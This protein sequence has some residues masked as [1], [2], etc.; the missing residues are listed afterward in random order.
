MGKF[1]KIQGEKKRQYGKSLYIKGFDLPT[2]SDITEVA[3]STLKKWRD[4]DRWE[5][6]RNSSF[7]ALS[8]LRNTILQSFIELKDGK[9]PKIK[10]DEAAKYAAAFE[11]LSDKK[12]VLCYMYEA[13]EMLT[14]ELT[15]DI[16]DTKGK[17]EK[18][19]ALEIL[20]RVRTHTD[21][22]ITKLTNET[23]ND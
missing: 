15:K 7:I 13:F 23:L 4:A 3:L 16:Q 14:C 17:K 5:T 19:L 6:A 12:K 8:E 22:I 9:K 11:R 18:E 1:T 10:P 2:I 21:S 20:K